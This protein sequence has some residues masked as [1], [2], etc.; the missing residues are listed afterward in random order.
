M[1]EFKK[2]IRDYRIPVNEKDA[3]R[4]FH[5]FDVDRSNSIDYSEFIRQIRVSKYETNLF[6][7]IGK[8]ERVQKKHGSQGIQNNG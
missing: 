7:S 5:I 3:E 8:N 2:A 4:L 6:N 1:T